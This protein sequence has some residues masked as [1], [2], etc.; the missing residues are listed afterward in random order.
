MPNSLTLQFNLKHFKN[1]ELSFSEYA[2]LLLYERK[3]NWELPE[4]EEIFKVSVRTIIR[5]R[6]RLV[7]HKYLAK[8]SERGLQYYLTNKMYKGDRQVQ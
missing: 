1:T 7:A 8:E 5:M 4:L 6:S 2:M 3:E